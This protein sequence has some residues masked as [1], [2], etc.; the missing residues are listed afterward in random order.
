MKT[1]LNVFISLFMSLIFVFSLAS[2]AFAVDDSLTTAPLYFDGNGNFRIMHI[3]DT[4]LN[5]DNIDDSLW[6]IADAIDKEQ[7]NLIVLTGDVFKAG[8]VEETEWFVDRIMSVFEVRDIP[9]AVAF[10]NHDSESGIISRE[11]LM[12]IYNR[13]SCS[14]SIDDGDQLSGCGTYNVPIY[15]KEDG[16]MKFNLWIFDS[17]AY[18]DEGRYSNVLEDQVEWYKA[19]SEEY[20]KLYG[21]KIYSLAF[22]HIIVP[23]V[24]DALKQV[25]TKRAYAYKRIYTDNEYYMFDPNVENHGTLQEMPCP[26]Y[27]NHG[28]VDA[29]VE[30]GDVLGMFFGHDHTNSFS[31]NYKGINI[32]NSLSTRFNGDA[33]STQYGYRI[34][35]INEDDTST[36]RTRSQR[37]YDAFTACD[38]KAYREVGDKDGAKLIDKINFL[39]FFEKNAELFGH[40]IVKVF[41]G[42]TVCYD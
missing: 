6:L 42:R 32:T 9:V 22:Q 24:Y 12:A 2:S 5:Y 1:K 16:K 33:Y 40:F 19:K 17:G 35:D 13:Y 34:I 25:K 21:E 20:E 11:D 10:G 26:G 39:G 37:W 18:D 7:P 23:E 29:M 8:T 31:V 28:Q 14:I 36:Y 38:S 4:H 15:S 41:T 3:T 30:R 27:Y